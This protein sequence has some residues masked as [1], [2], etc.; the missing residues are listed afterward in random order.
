[1]D[2]IRP[3]GGR[4]G[5]KLGVEAGGW[6][7]GKWVETDSGWI[8]IGGGGGK[9][10]EAVAGLMVVTEEVDEGVRDKGGL[11]FVGDKAERIFVDVDEGVEAEAG[12]IFLDKDEGE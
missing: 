9:G 10:I 3:L 2:D 11:V 7:V 1:M 4:V 12:R 5:N 6:N 8:S